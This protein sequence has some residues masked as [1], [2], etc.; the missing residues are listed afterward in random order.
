LKI[1]Y[2]LK[3]FLPK[4]KDYIVN[5]F[6]PWFLKYILPAIKDDLLKIVKGIFTILEEIINEFFKHQKSRREEEW[7]RNA[8][9][10]DQMAKT[11]KN[12]N[13]A[14][15]Y[16]AIANV[17]RE[18]TEQLRQENENLKQE[19]NKISKEAS[20]HVEEDIHKIDLS[21]YMTRE[22]GKVKIAG[23]KIPFLIPPTK[24]NN[25]MRSGFICF[26]SIGIGIFCNDER[27]K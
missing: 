3:D 24:K 5:T 22:Q 7:R 17:W 10:A 19:L 23:K 21:T 20:E 9:E 2:I 4:L 18:V 14:E 6:W 13:E 1:T 8:E 15:K 25:K 12:E 11:A 16:K 26:D 27:Y